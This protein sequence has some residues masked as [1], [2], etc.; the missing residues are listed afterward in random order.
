[1]DDKADDKKNGRANDE[2]HQGINSPKCKQR[3]GGK[4]SQHDKFAVRYVQ[5]SSDPILQAKTHSDQ[6]IDTTHQQTP[7]R[8]IQEFH[9][10]NYSFL[11]LAVNALQAA[12]K[13]T[14]IASEF[15]PHKKA[16]LGQPAY[17]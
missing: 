16:F 9:N 6:G 15:L 8:Y 1:M 17:Y 2:R 11:A 13:D 10:H 3:P 4:R 5:N 14:D 7:N 12:Q